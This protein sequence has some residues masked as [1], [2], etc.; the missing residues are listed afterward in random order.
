VGTKERD[1]TYPRSQH[2]DVLQLVLQRHLQRQADGDPQQAKLVHMG[3]A[4]HEIVW[5]HYRTG[6]GSNR[7]AQRDKRDDE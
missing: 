2:H 3:S 5:N 4:A 7:R 6:T 1:R